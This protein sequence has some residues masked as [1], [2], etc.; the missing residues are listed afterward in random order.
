MPTSPPIE[1]IVQRRNARE[2][3]EGHVQ[4]LNG[5]QFENLIEA[6]DGF[7]VSPKCA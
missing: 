2:L 3:I 1:K 6:F 4:K 7:F 5:F